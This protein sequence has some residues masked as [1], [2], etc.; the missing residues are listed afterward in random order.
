MTADVVSGVF[1]DVGFKAS[2]GKNYQGGEA[3]IVVVEAD[4]G[5]SFC[6]E[7]YAA[8]EAPGQVFSYSSP[9]GLQKTACPVAP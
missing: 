2:D 1:D 3:N 6:M 7:A 8:G 9:E 5:N 4:G